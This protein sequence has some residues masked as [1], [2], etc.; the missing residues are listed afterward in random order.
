MGKCRQQSENEAKP[1]IS[2]DNTTKSEYNSYIMKWLEIVV[3]LLILLT[4]VVFINKVDTSRFYEG[5][6]QSRPFTLKMDEEIYD[7]FYVEI[8]DEIHNRDEL[9]KKD[10]ENGCGFARDHN[11][12]NAPEGKKCVE[13]I[14]YTKNVN[15]YRTGK[16]MLG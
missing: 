10:Y 11:T 16:T 6:T 14:G 13:Y 3:T 8:Y 2:L 9:S 5:F 12:S 1:D 15:Q 7:D 4:I